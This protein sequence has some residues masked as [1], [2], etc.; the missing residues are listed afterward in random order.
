MIAEYHCDKND[1][2]KY[3]VNDKPDKIGN[4][5]LAGVGG[6][7]CSKKPD[8]EVRSGDGCDNDIMIDLKS[9]RSIRS[10]PFLPYN[11]T[12]IRNGTSQVRRAAM[13]WQHQ[14]ELRDGFM[15]YLLRWI[16]VFCVEH[17]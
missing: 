4:H 14:T 8:H 13:S 10:V 11:G 3:P 9:M 16:G 15:G 7:D 2:V 1:G 6:R 12:A 5:G 17:Y